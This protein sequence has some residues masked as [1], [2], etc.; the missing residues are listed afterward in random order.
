MK[1]VSS[2]SPKKKYIKK[3]KQVGSSA[4]CSGTDYSLRFSKGAVILQASQIKLTN[5][6]QVIQI[7][8][9]CETLTKPL[10]DFNRAYFIFISLLIISFVIIYSGVWSCL[11]SDTKGWGCWYGGDLGGPAEHQQVWKIKQPLSRARGWDQNRQG[12]VLCGILYIDFNYIFTF[13]I[14]YI[15]LLLF[16]VVYVCY[17]LFRSFFIYSRIHV[18]KDMSYS[19]VTIVLTLNFS[20]H[21]WSIR[22][23]W[24]SSKVSD[25]KVSKQ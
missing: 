22:W 8:N 4:F 5:M 24:L 20:S 23:R 21:S 25:D 19:T 1:F 6:Q 17:M 14:L 16:Y 12:L 3:K 15:D 2:I 9:P 11:N 18:V 7:P 13:Q 10:V